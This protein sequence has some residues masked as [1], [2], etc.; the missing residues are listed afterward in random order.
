MLSKQSFSSD[1]EP[2]GLLAGALRRRIRELVSIRV[3]PHGLTAQQFWMLIAVAEL[4]ESSLAE[5]AARRRADMPTS[6]RILKALA[7]QG[8]VSDAGSPEDR[9]R[10]RFVLT[11]RGRALIPK[12]MPIATEVRKG[13]VAGLTAAEQKAVRNGLRKVIEHLDSLLAQ[14]PSRPVA[15]ED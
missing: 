8:L 5:L 3:E 6:S 2:I 12:L 9:R 1:D 7:K 4:S 10:A 11:P 15:G 14:L 13:V